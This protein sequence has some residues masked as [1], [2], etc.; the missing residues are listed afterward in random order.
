MTIDHTAMSPPP[1]FLLGITLLCWG[2]MTGHALVGVL[3]A[4]LVEARHWIRLRWDFE[5]NAFVR[6]W[7]VSLLLI[8]LGAAL[9]WIDGLSAE[10]I[11]AFIMWFP[12]FLLPVQFVQAYG[13]RDKMPVHVF[14]VIARRR[15][16]RDRLL[17]RVVEIP[18]IVFGQVLF[19][20]ALLTAALGPNANVGWFLPVCLG[21][22]AWSLRAGT[23]AGRSPML[24]WL[25]VLALVAGIGVGGQR[26]LDG[27]FHWLTS[28]RWSMEGGDWSGSQMTRTAIGRLG[29]LKQSPEIVWRLRDVAGPPP[30]LLRTAGYNRYAQ[31]IWFHHQRAA[32]A[33]RDDDF[34]GLP[35]VGNANTVLYR[36][37]AVDA[38][39]DPA[40]ERLPAFTL[41]GAVNHYSLLPLPGDSRSLR[42]PQVDEIEANSLG[43]VRVTPKTGM[44]DSRVC[45][46]DERNFESPPVAEGDDAL[47]SD[48][49][50]PES[51]RAG[52]RA[53]V[54]E[55]GLREGSLAAKTSKLRQFF[56]QHF[57]YTRYLTLPS[58]ETGGARGQRLGVDTAITRFLDK[59]RR[60]HCEYFATATTLLLREAGVAA[61]YCIGFA[62]IEQDL[63]HHQ[64]TLRGTHAHAWC[65]AWDA[66][67]QRWSDVDLTPPD[68]SGLEQ[69]PLPS[70]QWLLDG[71]QRAREDILIWRNRPGNAS[72]VTAGIA[73]VATL[74]ISYVAL[75]LWKSRR[76]GA[77]PAAGGSHAL[78]P[79]H[80]LVVLE[81]AAR[82]RLGVRPCGIPL[83]PW[84]RQLAPFLPP[85]HRLD[86]ALALHDRVRFDPAW[87]EPA[88]RERLAA[89]AREI[90]AD[91][92]GTVG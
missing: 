77:L 75:R 6:A 39:Q 20:T 16:E 42:D 9:A 83:T 34:T 19:V 67:R 23:R 40:P 10:R 12:V 25:I 56:Q 33:T 86:Q 49:Q 63:P 92:R 73:I 52:I 65:R 70:Y 22:V 8:A 69:T 50:I 87:D 14:A 54:D 81:R 32:L 46:H 76:R 64:A 79:D 27:L 30:L 74:V 44:L 41:R 66:Q 35:V 45:W 17:G 90:R 36:V 55:L 91:L 7:H 29:R 61:R 72:R 3:A 89:M 24:A 59:S 47:A 2:G 13:M 21:L 80:P 84:L 4:L 88:D 15:I 60:G 71:W 26:A 37:M 11:Y 53:M 57:H 5:E 1:R 85:G 62:V 48:F 58:L 82:R 78:R 38:S 31:G 51:E 68:W 18:E 43:T 28:G